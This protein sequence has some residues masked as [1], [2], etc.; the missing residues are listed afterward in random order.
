MKHF[1][2]KKEDSF[3]ISLFLF[4]CFSFQTRAELVPIKFYYNAVVRRFLKTFR[5]FAEKRLWWKPFLRKF[6]LFKMDSVKG[7]FLSVFR[8]PFYGCFQT[9]NRNAFLFNDI[10]VWCKYSTVIKD[11]SKSGSFSLLNAPIYRSQI[12][13]FSL[14][15]LYVFFK[16]YSSQKN[17]WNLKAFFVK[18]SPLRIS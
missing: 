12:F 2:P 7:V 1:T 18:I 3:L 9:L 13:L 15:E 6:K 14:R 8:T 10:I 11:F 16:M 5:K 17:S 4:S